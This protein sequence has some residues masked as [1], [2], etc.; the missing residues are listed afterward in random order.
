MNFQ[1]WSASVELIPSV[2]VPLNACLGTC[3]GITFIDS[4]TVQESTYP[5]SQDVC[6]TCQTRQNIHRMVLLIVNDR[7]ELLD[8]VLT[9]GNVHPCS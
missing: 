7:G 5:L 3:T 8:F 1:A 4:T 2:I 6:R 9:P